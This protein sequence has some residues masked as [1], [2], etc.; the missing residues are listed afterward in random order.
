MVLNNLLFDRTECEAS[1]DT[2]CE[3]VTGQS[4]NNGCHGH[5]QMVVVVVTL[6]TEPKGA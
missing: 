1:R 4:W 2:G 3:L 6:D 5:F